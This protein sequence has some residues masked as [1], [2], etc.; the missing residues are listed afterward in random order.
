MVSGGSS[1]R[2]LFQIFRKLGIGLG[3]AALLLAGLEGILRLS[4]FTHYAPNQIIIWNSHMDRE[5][6]QPQGTYRF[7]PYWSWELRPG[8]RVADCGNERINAAGYRGPERLQSPSRGKLRVAILGDSSTFGMGVCQDETY[9]ALLERA[10]PNSEVLNF[11]VVGFTAFQGEKLLEGRVLT[12][13]PAFVLVAFG[14]IDELLPALGYDV[15]DKFRITSRVRPWAALWRDRLRGLRLLQ[16]IERSLGRQPESGI[17]LRAHENYVKWNGGSR[18]YMR[19]QSVASFERSLVRIVELGRSYGARV[20]LIGPPRQTMV[21][22][23]WPWANEYSA[24]IERV[25]S[26]L[27]VPFWDV[28]TAFRAVPNRDERLFLDYY[29]PNIAGH[30]L[31]AKLLA[32]KILHD[33]RSR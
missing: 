26:R 19:N 30:R 21:E 12:Y 4:G 2:L 24:A 15:D 27:Q 8:A 22:T 31:Y 16:L 5:M 11:G 23:R 28:R 3:I 17:E 6:K 32:D 20:V 9:A 13:H 1:A 10:L 18:D 33:A 25:A 7:Q 14:A 29:H